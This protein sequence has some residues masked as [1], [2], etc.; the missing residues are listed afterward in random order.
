MDGGKEGTYTAEEP[1][2]K[3]KFSRNSL[4][5]YMGFPIFSESGSDPIIVSAFPFATYQSI[6]KHYFLNEDLQMT[7]NGI[8][9][10]SLDSLWFPADDNKF[11]LH[12]GLCWI[13]DEDDTTL[14]ANQTYDDG[15]GNTQIDTNGAITEAMQKSPVLTMMRFHNYN[16]DYFTSA[17]FSPQRGPA[18]GVPVEFNKEIFKKSD[19]DNLLDTTYQSSNYSPLNFLKNSAPSTDPDNPTFP[20]HTQVDN[21]NPPDATK[22]DN[23]KANMAD[24]FNR[25]FAKAE[26]SAFTIT[27]IMVASQIQ[28]WLERNMQVKSE[29]ADFMAVHFGFSPNDDNYHKPVYIGGTTQLI[30]VQQVIQTS[31]SNTT[32]QG[33]ATGRAESFESD[34]VGNF[35]CNDY[36]IIMGIM[37]IMPDVYYTNGLDKKFK[38]RTRFDYIFPE[39]GQLPPEPIFNYEI[40]ANN[41]GQANS[42]KVFGYTGRYDNYRHNRNKSVSDLRNPNM[43]DFYSWNITREFSNVPTLQDNVFISTNKK[44]GTVS[45]PPLD[46]TL[47]VRMDH[48]PTANTVNPFIVQV[49]LNII[50]NRPIPYRNVP[51]TLNLRRS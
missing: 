48:F 26:S 44:Y 11:A 40:Y 7:G 13:M 31:E 28:L 18:Q 1:Y 4:G 23:Y 21:L 17:M 29:Y 25:L 10:R 51:Q 33:T 5:D 42:L 12:D 41:Y 2:I 50:A 8:N 14:E 39:F 22:V 27:D 20:I 19:F 49:G 30:N 34:F 16:K 9:N 37:C 36:G 47:N 6:Y 46:S 35:F 32:P 24:F 3:A 15:T 43:A 38:K 45:I